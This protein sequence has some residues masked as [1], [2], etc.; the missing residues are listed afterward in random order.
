[1]EILAAEFPDIFQNYIEIVPDPNKPEQQIYV[2]EE[3]AESTN[4]KSLSL[5]ETSEVSPSGSSP[6]SLSFSQSHQE[7]FDSKINFVKSNSGA[8][9]EKFSSVSGKNEGHAGSNKTVKNFEPKNNDRNAA[10]STTL[11]T[12]K[13]TSANLKPSFP[14]NSFEENSLTFRKSVAD[15]RIDMG[16]NNDSPVT[17][18]QSVKDI[19]LSTE[20]SPL[21]SQLQGDNGIENRLTSSDD[22]VNFDPS[23]DDAP[24]LD[25]VDQILSD[26]MLN[27]DINSN[28]VQY[29][30]DF[31]KSGYGCSWS[32]ST[33]ICIHGMSCPFTN[34]VLDLENLSL[35]QHDKEATLPLKPGK[36]GGKLPGF[37]VLKDT[38]RGL[39]KVPNEKLSPNTIQQMKTNLQKEKKGPAE[40]FSLSNERKLI[41]SLKPDK[42]EGLLPGYLVLK[43]TPRGL[44]KV[45]EEKI[46]PQSIQQM[47]DNILRG[48]P[49][50]LY[51]IPKTGLKTIETSSS[52]QMKV[53]FETN[54]QSTNPGLR[55]YFP[56]GVHPQFTR[57]PGSF[58]H[59][60]LRQT[61]PMS[62]AAVQTVQSTK[63]H[64]S[65]KPAQENS[66]L[67]DISNMRIWRPPTNTYVV[68]V[69]LK[70][71]SSP[72]YLPPGSGQDTPSFVMCE[73]C[74]DRFADR[75]TLVKHARNSHQVYQCSKCGVKTEGY[76]RMAS[77]SKRF[78]PKEPV[79][80]CN[81]GRTFGE[82][83]GYMK[84]VS[85]CGLYQNNS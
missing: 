32:N 2:Y 75:R 80:K 79:I 81:C 4:N 29:Q 46:A 47:K 68:R 3:F 52:R 13:E 85:T 38:P 21:D 15:G 18:V 16:A 35:I 34:K 22:G 43:H 28:K 62:I 65:S 70:Q 51:R 33:G 82:K 71:E 63:M 24:T 12:R 83:R 26:L 58:S 27:S 41:E 17:S 45:P 37:L 48:E 7:F 50:Q 78:H 84:H 44:M 72:T 60:G 30:L 64:V 6:Q 14:S 54:S 57:D 5:E 10:S 9:K 11:E 59:H 8:V 73:D 36:S 42:S 74:D 69:P 66:T 55:T 20:D 56:R 61:T 40:K 67:D 1:M 23:R 39:I 31:E 49:P 19:T 53:P 77:H 76:Y 25:E